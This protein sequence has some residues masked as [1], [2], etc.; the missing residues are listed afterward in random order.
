MVN[1]CDVCVVA[2]CCTMLCSKK[3]I[4]NYMMLTKSQVYSG[5]I[6][7]QRLRKTIEESR[8][9]MQI[10]RPGSVLVSHLIISILTHK[11]LDNSS[12][13]FYRKEMLEQPKEVKDV[14]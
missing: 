13:D 5:K 7:K 11:S 2:S 10:T 8:Q 3:K 12:Y 1:P 9:I 14:L 6:H 4:Y